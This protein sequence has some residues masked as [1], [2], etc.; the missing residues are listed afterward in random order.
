MLAVLV[1]NQLQKKLDF[2]PITLLASTGVEVD[3]MVGPP[4]PDP[5]EENTCPPGEPMQNSPPS[6]VGGHG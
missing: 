1:L 3:V 4:Y 5:L 2:Q 6:P